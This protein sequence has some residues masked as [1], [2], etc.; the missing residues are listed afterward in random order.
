MSKNTAMNSNSSLQNVKHFHK[1]LI[2]NR[3]EIA[4]RVIRT[5][6]KLGI[7][8]V[9]VYSDADYQALHKTLADE[10]YYIGP[11]PAQKSY[12]CSDKLIE[13]A[14]QS[15]AQAV[16][17][18]Y[19][20]LSENA[21]F[22]L[23][24]HDAGIHFIGPGHEAIKAMGSKSEAKTLMEKAG[25]PICPGYHGSDQSDETLI[26]EA[27]RIGYPLMVKAAL[28]GGGKGMRI[29]EHYDQ[30]QEG[31][32]SARR[33]ALKS[34]GDDHLLL[35][36]YITQPR[37]VEVQIF[38]DH[39][40]EGVYLFDRDCSLQRRHQKVIE[41]APAPDLSGS[42][43][44]SMGEAA[45]SAGRA[46]QY[47]GAGTVEFL[48]DGQRFYFME[49]N[50][51]LQVEHPVTEAI[52]G[53]DL[54]EWQLAIAAGA[55]LPLTQ[56][57][58]QCH[59]HALEA[60]I[61]A[62]SPDHDFLPSSGKIMGLQWPQEVDHIRIDT[63]V[64]QGDHISSHYDPMLAKLVVWA[65][66]RESAIDKMSRA[67]SDYQQAGLSDNRDF[68]LH[69]VTEPAF[70]KAGLSTHF[71]DQHPPQTELDHD[72]LRM[73]LIAG[74]LYQFH[75]SQYE[76]SL[77]AASA[78]SQKT[79]FLNQQPYL[80]SLEKV[81]EGFKVSLPDG[82]CQ[83]DIHWY[84]A[85]SGCLSGQLLVG[86]HT[87]FSS[88]QLKLQCRMFSLPEAR[89]KIFFPD[90]SV[91]LCLSGQC[92][93]AHDGSEAMSAPMN[94]TVSSVMVSEGQ[95]V[96]AG[97]P[98]LVMEAMKMEHTIH[99]PCDGMIESIFYKEGERVDAGSSLMSFQEALSKGTKENENA[100]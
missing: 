39:N 7:R 2:A 57:Q 82:Y 44:K 47:R 51:R 75:Q 21:D 92:L 23:A 28:G 55:S 78:P 42:M 54:V 50:T 11:S 5:A 15:G 63:G 12:L 48:V 18:G 97:A 41:E 72:Q 95:Q 59:G 77:P 99:A 74:A 14:K 38:F 10:A 9:A 6:R 90:F 98:L 20:F 4:C 49:M 36:S 16:H 3:G 84:E 94:G 30:L 81:S 91:E 17:P 64:Q 56:D 29:I 34:F 88:T 85:E 8:T 66:D 100:A 45:V 73:S 80:I 86:D 61:Y 67:L 69:M 13:V 24:C 31:L 58:L 53:Q 52:T 96:N 25:V 22:A 76:G 35:E 62:E 65:E 37:H 32:Q 68:L 79:L 71:I 70:R 89:L 43:R 83:A 33:E 27:E 40:N 46:I 93:T 26:L 60:R 19:G 87:E 1:I